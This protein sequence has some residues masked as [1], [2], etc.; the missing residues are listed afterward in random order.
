MANIVP[1]V[2]DAH[3]RVIRGTLNPGG[4]AKGWRT[5]LKEV[6][7]KDGEKLFKLMFAFAEGVPIIPRLPDGR[8]GIP[9]VPT[10]ADCLRAQI[11]LAHMLCGRPVTQAEIM[12]AEGASEDMAAI[13]ALDD[14]ELAAR[15]ERILRRGLAAL[16]AKRGAL[17]EVDAA[18]TPSDSTASADSVVKSGS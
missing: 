5:A 1:V 8:E 14:R 4:A 10:A 9:I 17:S 7:G 16:E 12:H 18:V 6:V 3:G 13:R 11:E 2:R 15:G